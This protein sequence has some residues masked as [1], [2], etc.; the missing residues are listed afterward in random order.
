MA[1]KG[2]GR[3]ATTPP[4]HPLLRTAPPHPHHRTLSAPRAAHRCTP[5]HIALLPRSSDPHRFR[6][7]LRR[8]CHDPPGSPRPIYERHLTSMNATKAKENIISGRRF[9]DGDTGN[10]SPPFM[11]GPLARRRFRLGPA[12]Q[13]GFVDPHRVGWVA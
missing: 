11:G 2:P 10:R 4:S 3:E 5:V 7:V 12:G 6:A 9:D 1:I 8:P 13:Y